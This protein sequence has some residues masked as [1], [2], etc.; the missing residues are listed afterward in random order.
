MTAE[1]VLVQYF[2]INKKVY[3]TQRF[4][5]IFLH[6]VF[7]SHLQQSINIELTDDLKDSFSLKMLTLEEINFTK[8][9]LINSGF[10]TEIV[11]EEWGI[12]KDYNPRKKGSTIIEIVP[13]YFITNEPAAHFSGQEPLQI[14]LSPNILS[15]VPIEQHHAIALKKTL[16]DLFTQAVFWYFNS[17]NY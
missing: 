11:I 3:I 5:K 12:E 2:R 4:I 14:S 17:S 16:P 8:K 7:H 6:D 10:Q 1:K 9:Y 15:A 13:G